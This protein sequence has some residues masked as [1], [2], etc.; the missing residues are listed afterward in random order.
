[1]HQAI[2]GFYFSGFV[3]VSRYWG[4]LHFGVC[5]CVKLGILV[6]RVC[7]C[8]QLLGDSTLRVCLCIKLLG[9][10]TFRG[11]PVRDAIGRFRQA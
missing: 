8:V 4:I 5:L 6:F 3:S 2:R 1:M 11:L 10:C 7:L 9:D